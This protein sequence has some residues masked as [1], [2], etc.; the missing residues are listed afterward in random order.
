MRLGVALAVLL[1]ATNAS[2]QNADPFFYGDEAALASGAVVA[3]GRDS[4]SSWYNPAGFGGLHRGKISANASTFGLRFR[5]IPNALTVTSG[6]QVR[7]TTELSSTD[8]ISV[9]N[10]VVLATALTPRVALAGGL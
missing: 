8:V 7:G 4:G 5:T 1:I 6:G 2:A 10:A 9:P 3:S